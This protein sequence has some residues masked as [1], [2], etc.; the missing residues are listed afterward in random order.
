MRGCGEKHIRVLDRLWRIARATDSTE[1][2]AHAVGMDPRV[3]T[4]RA[5]RERPAAPWASA[6]TVVLTQPVLNIVASA[7]LASVLFGDSFSTKLL[8]SLAP[9]KSPCSDPAWVFSQGP[10]PPAPAAPAERRVL[11]HT[12]SSF[13]GSLSKALAP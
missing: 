13:T 10:P 3:C 6:Q 2:L 1:T 9:K 4:R 12:V 8:N 7:C 11:F 5:R